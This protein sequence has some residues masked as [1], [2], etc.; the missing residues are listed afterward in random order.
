VR[1]LVNQGYQVRVLLRNSSSLENLKDLKFERANG[2]LSDLPSLELALKDVDLVFHVAGVV[3]AKSKADYFLANAEGTKNLALASLKS[4]SRLKRVIYL[5]S[6]AAAGPSESLQK[7][8]EEHHVSRPVSAYGESKLEGEREILKFAKDLPIT[9]IRP[10]I[11]YGPKDRGLF[12]IL[13]T[14]ARGLKPLVRG[15]T[16]TGDK[17]YS[18]VHVDDLCRGIILAAQDSATPSGEVYYLA[19]DEIYKYKDILNSAS[20]ALGQKFALNLSVPSGVVRAAG[21]IAHRLS[22]LTG[23]ALPL[24]RDKV[25]EIL[26]DFWIC[27]NQKAKLAFR[28]NPEYNLWKGMEQTIQWYKKNGWL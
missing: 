20:L 24:N 19:S 4:G 13:K 3:A 12:V 16:E 23:Q 17:Y 15:G 21:E 8:N 9:I 22:Q 7:P 10:P 26:P 25:N 11:V 18:V 14:V 6:L 28:F 2:M 1:D 27:S 5:S